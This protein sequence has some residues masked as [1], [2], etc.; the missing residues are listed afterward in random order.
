MVDHLIFELIDSTSDSHVRYQN[1]LFCCCV[2]VGVDKLTTYCREK[3]ESERE[4]E[5]RGVRE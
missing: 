1:F 2:V 4:K 5:I 3:R